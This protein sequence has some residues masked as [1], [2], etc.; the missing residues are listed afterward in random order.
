[1]CERRGCRCRNLSNIIHS[2]RTIP[3]NAINRR[4]L[5]NHFYNGKTLRRPTT[6]YYY[7]L[8]NI[9]DINIDEN[10]DT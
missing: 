2:R 5:S 1:M 9:N 6:T 7:Y 4:D 3:T 8:I 10:A